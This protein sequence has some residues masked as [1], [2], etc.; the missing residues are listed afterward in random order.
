M[1]TE[2]KIVKKYDAERVENETRGNNTAK[3]AKIIEQYKRDKN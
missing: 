1:P 2:K 3:E